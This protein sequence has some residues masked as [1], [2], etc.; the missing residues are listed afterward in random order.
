MPKI[1]TGLAQ[2]RTSP[3]EIQIL[4]VE[5]G[6]GLVRLRGQTSLVGPERFLLKEPD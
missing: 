2:G 4:I 6:P 5:T 3:I 1:W